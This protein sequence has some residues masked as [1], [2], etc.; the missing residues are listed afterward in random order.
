MILTASGSGN[1]PYQHLLPRGRY[2]R[3]LW[4]IAYAP[5]KQAQ[6]LPPHDVVFNAVADPDITTDTLAAVENYAARCTRA[7]INRPDRVARTLRSSMPELLRDIEGVVV[8]NTIRLKRDGSEDARTAA[9]RYPLIVRPVGNHGGRGVRLVRAPEN[10]SARLPQS[11]AC[12]VTEF[13][14]YRSRDVWYRKYRVIFVDREPYPYHL[15]IGAQ[16]LLHYRTADMQNDA[17]RRDEEA[18][19]LRDP[20]S[21]LGPR[22]MAALRTIAA[23]IDLD[24][25]GIDFSILP[26]GQL[27]FF[28]C[29]ATM[30]V[31]PEDLGIFDYKNG[32]VSAITAATENMIAKR[33]AAAA[34]RVA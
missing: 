1:V 22:V 23:R 26:D 16:W 29:N 7:L 9:L 17:A 34:M 4:H 8:P 19:F 2:S 18:R 25:A 21:V 28:E 31:H 32:A 10:L 20:S 27:L 30:L 11:E 14:D 24:Y 6:T 15:A 3:I 12:Y 33:L 13:V 5:S